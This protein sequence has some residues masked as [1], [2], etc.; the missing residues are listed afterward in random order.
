MTAIPHGDILRSI[1]VKTLAYMTIATAILAAG[2]WAPN[3]APQAIAAASVVDLGGEWDSN[4]GKVN[5]QMVGLDHAGN[6][7]LSGG[8]SN[9][10]NQNQF[11]YALFDPRARGG[12][13]KIEYYIPSTTMYGYAEFVLDASKTKFNGE[14]HELGKTGPWTMSR[15][16]NTFVKSVSNLNTLTTGIP[17]RA[18]SL[19]SVT[20]KW[21]SN[22]GL[23]ELEGTGLGRSVQLKGKITRSDGKTTSI[24]SGS[25]IRSPSVLLKLEY[26]GPK[27]SKGT[28]KFRADDFVGGK[29]M[30][31]V[32]EEGGN[33]GNWI[34]T[35]PI[36]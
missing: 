18:N 1:R 17:Q 11:V 33:T 13:L 15:P 10:T 22:F 7:V 36:N 12:T 6:V 4:F 27:N 31:G 28:A 3:L 32:Y 9:G 23:V 34:L 35:R 26:V 21:N 2:S 20:G 14:Y 19:K 8:W 25:F 29:V 30:I 16:A 5:L 24:T